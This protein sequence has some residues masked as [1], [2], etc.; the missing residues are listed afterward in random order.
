MET[1]PEPRAPHGDPDSARKLV[2]FPRARK[3]PS[4]IS[5]RKCFL[6]I[7]TVLS[8]S[9]GTFLSSPHRPMIIVLVGNIGMFTYA[10]YVL[11]RLQKRAG[12]TGYD[13]QVSSNPHAS[14][15]E[16]LHRQYSRQLST[17]SNVSKSLLKQKANVER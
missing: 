2:G 9:Q 7:S 6:H 8:V 13:R 14:S 11:Q 10:A 15:K 4:S 16:P 5:M 3:A 17:V 1:Q 12:R